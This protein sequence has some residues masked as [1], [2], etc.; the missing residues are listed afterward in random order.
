M[1]LTKKSSAPA[2]TAQ[3]RLARGLS[4]V[5]AKTMDRRT[6]LRRSGFAAGAGAVAT[7]LPFQLIGEAQANKGKATGKVEV[8][9]TVCSHC[10]VGCAVD[11]HVQDGVWVRQEPV[12]D[13]PINLGSHCTKGASLRE[14]GMTQDS[15]RLKHPMKLEGGKWKRISWDVALDEISKK[16]TAIREKDGPDALLVIGSSKHNNEQAYLLRKWVS[17]WGTNNTDHQ[18]RVCHSSTVAG[19]AQTWGYGAMTNSYNDQQNSKSL[20]FLGSN[21][22]EAHPVSMLHTLHARENGCKVIVAD[23]RFTRTAA[24]ADIYLRFRSGT[25]VPLIFGILH[26]IFKNGWED[27]EYLRTRVYGMDQVKEE[28]MK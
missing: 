10:S 8:K 20:F 25:D 1:L 15:H 21:A 12:F 22:A 24:K 9:R 27:K 14:Y 11:A 26:H 23:P 6:F 5:M 17:L 28:V 16:L 2:A 18:A 7:Q 13:S 3:S 19:V 4:S